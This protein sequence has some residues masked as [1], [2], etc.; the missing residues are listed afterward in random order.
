MKI[1]R[2]AQS[3]V[4]IETNNKRILIDPGVYQYEE[5]LVETDWNNIDILLISHKDPDHFHLPAI[6]KIL[7]KGKTEF[8]TSSDVAK[9]CTEITPKIIKEG[10]IINI[11]GI[12]IEVT[13]AIHGF[14]PFLRGKEPQENFGF[15]IDDN[16]K[17]LY[18]CGDSICFDNNYKCDILLVPISNH[19]LVMGPFEAAAFA[20]ETEA[21]LV[22]PYHYESQ[23]FPGNLEEAK[24]QFEKLN[25]N[26]KILNYKETI[27]I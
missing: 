16:E 15:I 4:L 9:N 21:G 10:E 5:S 14:I 1:T 8:Y 11:F 25:L 19:G 6:Q 2:Y 23:K 13:K 17:K 18:F 20:K 3:C 27:T 24:I 12:K 26:Y 7:E 22:I